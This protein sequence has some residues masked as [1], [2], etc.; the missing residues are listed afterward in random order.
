M[1]QTVSFYILSAIAVFSAVMVVTRRGIF[2][3]ALF[4]AAALSTVAGFFIL[5]GADFLAAVQILLYVGGILVIIVMAVML[6]S[7][8]QSKVHPQVNEQW[9]PS[10]VVCLG[11]LSVIFVGL[12]RTDFS[13]QQA[14]LSPSIVSIGRLLFGELALPFELVSLVLLASLAG[15]VLFSRKEEG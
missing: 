10:L 13:G 14:P 7:V 3:C 4:L 12:K 2:T 8:Q 1:V 9:L 5:L 11:L 6:S 15:A